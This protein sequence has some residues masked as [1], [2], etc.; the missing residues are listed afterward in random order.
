MISMAA[1]LGLRGM[2]PSHRWRLGLPSGTSV[3]SSEPPSS[4]S[5]VL[6]AA[7]EPPLRVDALA[8]ESALSCAAAS[9]AGSSD[10]KHSPLSLPR[11][12][13]VTST[14]P[15]SGSLDPIGA[16]MMS[17]DPSSEPRLSVV[18]ASRGAAPPA[19][20]LSM[21]SLL[22]VLDGARS[23]ADASF[24]SCACAA[25]AAAAAAAAAMAAS[26]PGPSTSLP[27]A[28]LE[29]LNLT[30]SLRS[31][32]MG[33]TSRSFSASAARTA[34][35]GFLKLTNA[36]MRP[37]NVTTSSTAPKCSNTALS[38]ERGSLVFRLPSHRCLEARL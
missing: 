18:G 30:T 5:T 32:V 12:P 26:V 22:A 1:L 24:S 15:S 28:F 16:S 19:L 34:S 38:T 8:V 3:G 23:P 6:P 14:Q 29:C 36:Y 10:T 4:W 9:S 2:L 31:P 7:I 13:P 33:G 11:I 20:L 17:E 21:L 27:S 35:S 37:G 25:S